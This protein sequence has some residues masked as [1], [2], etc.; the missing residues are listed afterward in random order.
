MQPSDEALVQACRAGDPA[1]WEALVER[2][3]RLVYAIARHSGLDAE[4][5][6]DVFQ[7]VFELLIEALPRIERPA[8]IGAW[9]ATTARHEAWRVSRGERMAYR[10]QGEPLES[11]RAVADDAP[12]PEAQLLRL[13]QQH[14]V[15]LAV[16]SLDERC[17]RLLQLLFYRPDTPPYAAIAA[18]LGMAEGAIGPTRARCLDKLR[19]RLEEE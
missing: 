10:M 8:L 11:A 4:Q 7:R 1:A 15:R 16:D 12:L 2:Y 3:Q 17:R 14:Q 6:A 5:S 9:L 13:E 19:R 18:T